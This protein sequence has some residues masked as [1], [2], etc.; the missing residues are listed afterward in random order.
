MG[1]GRQREWG[2]GYKRNGGV[3]AKGMGRGDNGV[4]GRA[5]EE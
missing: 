5:M 3:E 1:K 2:M 4:R